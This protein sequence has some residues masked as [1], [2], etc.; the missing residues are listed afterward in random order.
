MKKEEAREIYSSLLNNSFDDNLGRSG[1]FLLSR[2]SEILFVI[3]NKW[4]A[5]GST[6][7]YLSVTH[8]PCEK[9]DDYYAWNLWRI[10]HSFGHREIFFFSEREEKKGR[11]KSM[12][13]RII[14]KR[15]LTDNNLYR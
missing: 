3:L 4:T 9:L 13:L 14:T 12:A 10:S 8:F 2:G 1:E 7:R 11:E 5:C 6:T 15:P